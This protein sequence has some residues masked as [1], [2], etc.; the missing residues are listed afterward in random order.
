MRVVKLA[1]D[2]AEVARYPA[3]V[4]SRTA[5]DAWVVV[6]AIWGYRQVDVAGLAFAPGDVLAEWFSP[7][8]DF[9]AFAVHAPDGR[10]KGWYANVAFP[11]RLDAGA[12]P[13][14]LTWH[15]LYVDVIVLPD[16]APVVHDEDELAE[17]GLAQSDPEL[18][19][20][21]LRARDELLDRHERRLPPFGAGSNAG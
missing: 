18:H 3:E 10:F 19:E 5:D 20:R 7:R 9:N 17:S 1:P 13:P 4:V 16:G 6:R 15:D 21:I 12:S 2:G 8:H 14:L 11:A